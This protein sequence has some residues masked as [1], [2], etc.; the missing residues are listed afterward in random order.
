MHEEIQPDGP[1]VFEQ[2]GNGQQ[3]CKDNGPYHRPEINVQDGQYEPDQ[4]GNNDGQG[5][6]DVHG[7][8]EKTGL[9]LILQVTMR[10]IRGHVKKAIESVRMLIDIKVT[11]MTARAFEVNNAVKFA[12]F[13]DHEGPKIDTKPFFSSFAA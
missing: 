11:L 10:A 1:G 2:G 4:S 5:I 7:T 13:F 6:A 9:R 3:K 8:I 12:S